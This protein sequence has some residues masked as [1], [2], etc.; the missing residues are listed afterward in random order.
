MG[1][2]TNRKY[3]YYV[4]FNYATPPEYGGRTMCN[5]DIK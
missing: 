1:A 5:G 4:A 3:E 2:I